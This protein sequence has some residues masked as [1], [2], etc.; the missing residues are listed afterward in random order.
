MYIIGHRGTRGYKPEN[1][2]ASF[3]NAITLGV[4]MIE[5]DVH[6][7][8]TGEV[9]VI[10]DPT[11]ARTTNGKGKVSDLTFDQLR[12][13]DAGNGQTIPL[14]TEVLDLVQARLAINI[15]LKGPGTARAVAAIIR[16]YVHNR[17]WPQTIFMVSAF[18]HSELELFHKL[19]PRTPVATL[20]KR[21]PRS[22]WKYEKTHPVFAVDVSSQFVTRRTVSQ[23]HKQ[24]VR[25]YA[26]TVN[27][28]RRTRLLNKL[29]VDGVF[30]D[31][32]DKV[33]LAN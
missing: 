26:F 24:G 16:E 27:S 11:V 4:D 17:G 21:V 33:A 25:V 1:T 31:Y 30:T 14:L 2:L 3:Q 29:Q 20:W 32:P 22:Y 23:A 7:A 28:K 10:H 9:V 15:E 19:S 6:L 5:L 8:K 18:D 13:L 12:S